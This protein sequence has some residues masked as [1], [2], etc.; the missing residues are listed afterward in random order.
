MKIKDNGKPARMLVL[1]AVLFAFIAAAIVGGVGAVIAPEFHFRLVK[2]AI[3]PR[4]TQ[5]EYREGNTMPYRD[6]KG[7]VSNRTEVFITCVAKDGKRFEGKAFQGIVAVIG[8]YFLVFMA[9]AFLL[10]LL[11]IKKQF[12]NY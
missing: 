12:P 9:P 1:I 3:C 8:F 7:F 4:E 6:A 10:S 2:P 11:I 5:L